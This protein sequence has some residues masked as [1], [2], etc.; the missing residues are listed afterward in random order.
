MLPDY[1]QD[2]VEES[3]KEEGDERNGEGLECGRDPSLG[4]H[5]GL[6]QTHDS[7]A[8]GWKLKECHSD[9]LKVKIK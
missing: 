7:Q 1:H 9:N 6:E 3:E 4:R 2:V 5:G 8:E